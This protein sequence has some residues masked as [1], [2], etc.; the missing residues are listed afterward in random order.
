M[1]VVWAS[2]EATSEEVRRALREQGRDL[3]D[4]SVR[5]ILS[6][7]L[8][9]GYLARYKQGRQFVYSAAVPE[10]QAKASMLTDLLKR[11]YGGSAAL[12][13]ASLLDSRQ[14]R[15]EDLREIRR[16]IADREGSR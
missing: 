7:L 8:A 9:K 15:P 12:L 16:L 14:V 13:V 10:D 5:K 3:A 11:A 1:H 2:G 4:G 6:I